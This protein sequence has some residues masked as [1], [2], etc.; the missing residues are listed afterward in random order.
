MS[1]QTGWGGGEQQVIYLLEGLMERGHEVLLAV[2][3]GTPLAQKA[4][5]SGIPLFII[6]PI[7]EGDP[8]TAIKIARKIWSWKPDLLH[9]HCPHAQML[10]LIA[11]WIA[12]KVLRIASRRVEFTIYRRH[13]FGVNWLK[14]RLGVHHYLAVSEAAKRGLIRDKMP[15]ERVS[16]VYSGIDLSR[17][18]WSPPEDFPTWKKQKLNELGIPENYPIVAT[19][20]TVDVNKDPETLL[21]AC[22]RASESQPFLALFLGSGP[23]LDHCKALARELGIERWTHF[24]GFREDVLDCM[25]VC[26]VYV[27]LSLQEGLGTSI[28]DSLALGKPTIATEVGGTPEILGENQNGLLI[29]PQ[30]PQALLEAIS[31]YLQNPDYAQEL[32]LSGK[33]YV[34]EKFTV[35][36]MVE[37]TLEEYQRLLAAN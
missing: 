23:L 7:N 2:R 28:L 10:C 20:G 8:F 25:N 30:S 6:N 31:K 13:T 19:C 16:V 3:P 33:S 17:R 35:N 1:G 9:I 15:E 24:T 22:K 37:G 26:D 34:G 14:Y 18:A 5:D 4:Q 27:Q 29:P 21:H 32:A 36:S 11:S 12:P